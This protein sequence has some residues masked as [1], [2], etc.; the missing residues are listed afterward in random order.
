M[1][2]STILYIRMYSGSFKEYL[3]FCV[4]P[5][6]VAFAYT[7][8]GRHKGVFKLIP[9]TQNRPPS[10]LPS[11]IYEA[12][13]IFIWPPH[14]LVSRKKTA[15]TRENRH[16]VTRTHDIKCGN[17]FHNVFFGSGP[18]LTSP[19]VCPFSCAVRPK[20]NIHL[21]FS[22][23]YALMNWSPMKAVFSPLLFV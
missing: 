17:K 7:V 6:G 2:C 9:H 8:R 11:I 15:A 18:F 4:S 19:R 3:C 20:N 12:G 10:V 22:P 21:L 1:L 23:N 13:G 16:T 14:F 5:E